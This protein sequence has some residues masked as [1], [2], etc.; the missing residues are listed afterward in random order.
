MS[1][2]RRFFRK[3]GL[4][5]IALALILIG[6]FFIADLSFRPIVETVNAYECHETVSQ[7]INSAVLAEIERGG[8]E[9][10]SLVNLSTNSD[11]EVIS[12]ESNVMNINRLKTEVAERV[13][14]EL[15][16]LS[17]ININ[18]PV[19]TLTGVQLLH[20]RGFNVG[21]SVQPLG[22]ATTSIIS[23]FSAAG[24]N[25]TLHRIVIEISADVDAIIPGF[26]TRVPVSTTIV[27]AETVIVGR[28]PEAYTHVITESG[29]LAGTLNDFGAVVP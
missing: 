4:K 2:T 16:R 14:R 25:Q 3:L 20:G 5:L 26:S 8:A 13:E 10:S 7:I 11:G 29:D 18:I 24:I 12:V 1:K 6:T 15:E 19:G 23:E 9:Y 28:V 17:A 27:A 21:M 22:Y